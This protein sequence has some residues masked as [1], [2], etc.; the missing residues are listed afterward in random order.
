MAAEDLARFCESMNIGY[1]EWRDGIGYDLDALARLTPEEMSVAEDSIVQRGIRDWRDVEAL[2]RIESPRA[3]TEIESAVSSTDLN[4][5]VAATAALE[6]TGRLSA[7]QVE[8]IILR[9]LPL[10]TIPNGMVRALRLAESH[11]TKEV[12]RALL[13]NARH[14]NADIRVHAAALVHFL[15]GKSSS[16]FDW[17]HRPFYLRFG[18]ADPDERERAYT[19]LCAAIGVD[20]RQSR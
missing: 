6:R 14:G 17:A 9:T 7:A 3:I 20:A 2:I 19:E 18:S 11:A 16:N 8:S 12:R 5:R 13:W 15:Y 4:L 10:V 1:M